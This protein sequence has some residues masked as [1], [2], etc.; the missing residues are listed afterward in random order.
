MG[1]LCAVYPD[2]RSIVN[3]SA[4]RKDEKTTIRVAW[5]EVRDYTTREITSREA[6]VGS[7][8]EAIVKQLQ[9]LQVSRSDD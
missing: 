8:R 1:V 9:S 2:A 3:L 7:L 6:L 4:L 5:D